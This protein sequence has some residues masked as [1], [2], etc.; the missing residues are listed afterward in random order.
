MGK[1]AVRV[2]CSAQCA[3]RRKTQLRQQTFVLKPCQWCN[4][5]MP[6]QVYGIKE[7]KL[8]HA[9]H[10]GI[11]KYCNRACAMAQRMSVDRDRHPDY[12][13]LLARKRIT[14][15]CCAHC[16]KTTGRL[17]VHH[18]SGRATRLCDND[19]GNLQVLCQSCHAKLH[20]ALKRQGPNPTGRFE[21]SSRTLAIRAAR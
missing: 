11:R 1:F 7:R 18:L 10:Y 21:P 9:R 14:I 17:G 13:R 4:K 6:R 3:G 19:P 20:W 2:T 8:E 15:K 16:R 5:I 12:M